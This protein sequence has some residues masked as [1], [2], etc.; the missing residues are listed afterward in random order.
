MCDLCSEQ[1]LY[2]NIPP[3]LVPLRV[4]REDRISSKSMHFNIH[5][6]IYY[7][8]KVDYIYTIYSK[9][10]QFL[11]RALVTKIVYYHCYVDESCE[12]LFVVCSMMLFL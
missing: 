9:I 2:V 7:V 12:Q 10:K 1:Q 4:Y 8:A 3:C 5:I 6:S 11:F